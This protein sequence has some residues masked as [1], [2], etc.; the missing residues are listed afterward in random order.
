MKNEK[1]QKVEWV[2]TNEQ[3]INIDQKGSQDIVIQ[4]Y[5]LEI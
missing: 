2:N 1:K 5:A 4:N 3:I